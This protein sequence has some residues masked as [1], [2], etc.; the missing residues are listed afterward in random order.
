MI[1]I[2]FVLSIFI[3][4]PFG[5]LFY[6]KNTEGRKEFTNFY[7]Q[8]NTYQSF[9]SESSSCY[10]YAKDNF[11][12]ID[13]TNNENTSEEILSTLEKRKDEIKVSLDYCNNLSND[14]FGTF[15]CIE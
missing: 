3:S 11:K 13:F 1:S 14:I 7:D 8:R 10:A 4:F 2:I 15:Y 6:Y 5:G 12:N 9:I